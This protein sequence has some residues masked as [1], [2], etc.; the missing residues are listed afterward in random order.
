MHS[1][2]DYEAALREEVFS[3][4]ELKGESGNIIPFT[5]QAIHEGTIFSRGQCTMS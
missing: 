4:R 5:V 3:K 1:Q 2:S